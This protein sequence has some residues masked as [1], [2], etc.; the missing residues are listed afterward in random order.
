MQRDVRLGRPAK[1]LG[2]QVALSPAALLGERAAAGEVTRMF[3]VHRATLYRAQ[4]W[5]C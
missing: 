4:R 3:K 5:L 2:N 1:L